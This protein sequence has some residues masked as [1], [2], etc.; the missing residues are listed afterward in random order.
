MIKKLL[1]A[2]LIL[3]FVIELIL[4]LGGFFFP[5]KTFEQFGVAYNADT[6]FLGY[7]ISWFIL[8]IT[9]LIFILIKQVWQNKSYSLLA[10]ILGFWWVGLGI[11]IYIAFKKVDN[12]F[13]DSI[14]GALLVFLTWKESKSTK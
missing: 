4:C 6:K 7:I 12:L 1:K 3:A 10:Y 13:L 8:L 9:V 2:L 5:E 14:K 11:G